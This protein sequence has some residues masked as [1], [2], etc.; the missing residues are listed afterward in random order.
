MGRTLRSKKLRHLLFEHYE[1][2][3]A[4]CAADLGDDWHADHI[5]PWC[6]TGRTNI[7]EMQ[8]TC[9]NCNLK[10]GSKMTDYSKARSGFENV[11]KGTVDLIKNGARAVSIVAPPRYGKSSMVRVIAHELLR[12]GI[13]PAGLVMAP[14]TMIPQSIANKEKCSADIKRY[15]LQNKDHAWPEWIRG[16]PI[17]KK[18][19][20]GMYRPILACSYQLMQHHGGAFVEWVRSV[21]ARY[22]T[23]PVIFCDEAHYLSETKAW[24]S[25]IRA[26]VEAGAVI[27]LLTATPIRH[28]GDSLPGVRYRNAEDSEYFKSL[29]N[30]RYNENG[31]R[32]ADVYEGVKS[33][34]EVIPD[35]TITFGEA[36][37]ETP[38]CIAYLSPVPVDIDVTKIV[39]GNGQSLRIS[40]LSA[41]EARRALSAIMR[42]REVISHLVDHFLRVHLP[43][44]KQGLQGMIRCASRSQSEAADEEQIRII[45]DEI[46]RRTR[47]TQRIVEATMQSE[48]DAHKLID[49]FAR[50]RLGDILLVK[51]MGGVGLDFPNVKTLGDFSTTRSLASAVQ[52][53]LRGGMP[54]SASVFD[55]IYV[56]DCLYS[57]IIN[58]VTDGGTL[59]ARELAIVEEQKT[60]EQEI[61]DGES[62]DKPHYLA[63]GAHLAD[64]RDH[65]GNTASGPEASLAMHLREMFPELAKSRTLAALAEDIRKDD[66]LRAI[67]VSKNDTGL[68]GRAKSLDSISPQSMRKEITLRA[69]KIAQLRGFGYVPK[70]VDPVRFDAYT[71][72]MGAV[73]G[74][75]CAMSGVERTKTRKGSFVDSVTDKEAELLY[76][77]SGV[78]LSRAENEAMGAAS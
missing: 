71:R 73:Y 24:G 27:V 17:T 39:S 19:F 51:G 72:S 34:R 55:L 56:A 12:L 69:R 59:V 66:K 52:F 30:Y 8:P 5:V 20:D 68:V 32:I 63:T 25:T 21:V 50:G 3:C 6:I 22:G 10:K 7:Y 76:E 70:K 40:E 54:E 43:K 26:L 15:N 77:A 65:Q 53:M 58:T 29:R 60:G 67:A 45:K 23:R 13:T 36:W 48:E 42:D 37:R 28:D 64:C 16:A 14:G 62:S 33:A 35:F 57:T 2:K 46:E 47:G 75:M 41:S 49:Q 78:L 38:Q 11:V 18:T 44:S 31:D 74:Q 1:G 61:D 4:L 9:P